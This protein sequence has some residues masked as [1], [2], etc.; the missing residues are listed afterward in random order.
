MT[1]ARRTIE[2]LEA[3]RDPDTGQPIIGVLTAQESTTAAKL[4]RSPTSYRLRRAAVS[5]P[6]GWQRVQSWSASGPRRR[7]PP[8]SLRHHPGA[9]AGHRAG[10]IE[11]ANIVDLAPTALH[12][13]GLPVPDG[14]GRPRADGAVHDGRAVATSEAASSDRS[15]VV[16]R[17][18]KR[19][20]EASLEN[21]GYI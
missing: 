1:F 18:R 20:I 19:R 8:P 6:T 17:R 14:H 21:L 16:T 4:Q 10:E 12:A 2:A 11:G 5:H 13:M 3:A 7:R 15:D 9:R